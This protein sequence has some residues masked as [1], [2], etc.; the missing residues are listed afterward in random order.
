MPTHI[1]IKQSVYIDLMIQ[2]VEDR[3]GCRFMPTGD[4]Q[5]RSFCPFHADTRDSVRVYV[6]KYDVVRFHCFGQCDSHWDIYDIIEL[7]E[8]CSFREAQ[9]IWAKFLGIKDFIPHQGKSP[10]MPEPDAEP[11]P[12]ETI[13]FLEPYEPNDEIKSVFSE[14]AEFYNTL[15]LSSPEHFD[16]VHSYL[17]RRGLEVS[18]VERF[19]IGYAPAYADEKYCGR[20]L[21]DAFLPRFKKDYL[22]FQ[23]FYKGSLVRLLND[24]TAKGFGYYRMQIDFSRKDVF[25]S[26]YGDYFAG[27]IVFPILNIA[28]QTVGFIGRRPDNRG[29]RW[30]K[31]QNLAEQK[32]LSTKSWL[33][34]IEKAHRF[35]RHYRTVIIVE[36]I[37][38]YFA[39]YHLL[40]DQGRPVVVS[41]L[42]SHLSPEALNIFKSL[43]VEHFIVAY[44]WDE[45]GKKGITKVASQVG[46]TV[47]YLGG[48]KPGQDPYDKLKGVSGAISGFSLKH[49]SESAKKH[50]AKTEKPIS[51]SFISCGPPEQ[52]N[53]LFSPAQNEQDPKLF[54]DS[55]VS[56][57]YYNVDDF[58]LLLSYDH[59]N[60][61]M[62]DQTIIEITKLLEAR[63]TKPQSDKV[64]TIPVNF[65]QTEGY[66]DLGPAIMLWLRLVIEQQ[67]TRRRIRQ[68]DNVLAEWL[69]TSRRTILTYKRKL[70]QLGY[71]NISESTRPAKLSIRYF[72]K[73]A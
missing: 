19:Q 53:V 21:L 63:H 16:K 6:D 15:L 1:E 36:G 59:R 22:S 10:S 51:M 2:Y 30:L 52:R 40:Q 8:K 58:M 47:Y 26:V 46:A 28:G 67:T 62:L 7:R 25:T 66:T 44:D 3:L 54:T 55:M 37:F 64:F 34:G 39:F 61:A 69:N 23:P 38:D 35:I 11:E 41:T 50:Q 48:M 9:Q 70:K 42:G 45:A 71:L 5:Y 68:P 43:G 56:E 29:I 33:Y 20:A 65:L 73:Q 72:P 14:A 18:I 31:Q 32:V 60:K 49:L 4:N 57:Y 12:D 24:D 27:R 17:K 13:G